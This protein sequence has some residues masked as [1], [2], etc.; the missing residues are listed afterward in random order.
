MAT[1]AEVL[2][3]DQALEAEVAAIISTLQDVEAQLAALQSGELTP[4]QQAQVD[5]IANSITTMTANIAAA[6]PQP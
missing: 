4:E 1:L 5:Q 2:A 6:L 3:D